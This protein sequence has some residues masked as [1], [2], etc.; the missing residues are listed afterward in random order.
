[1]LDTLTA[2]DFVR[3]AYA[4]GSQPSYSGRVE[5]VTKDNLTIE[6]QSVDGRGKKQYRSFARNKIVSCHKIGPFVP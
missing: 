3:V 6:L 4:G 2:K 1:M 5:K